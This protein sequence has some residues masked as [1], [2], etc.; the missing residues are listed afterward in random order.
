MVNLALGGETDKLDISVALV[1][2]KY[3]TEISPELIEMPGFKEAF[4]S[5]FSDKEI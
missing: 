2:G 3:K 1:L 4:G 5:N